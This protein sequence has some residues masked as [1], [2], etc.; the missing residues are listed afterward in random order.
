MR[1][2][3]VAAVQQI[4]DS[5]PGPDARADRAA[6]G[7]ET[8]YATFLMDRDQIADQQRPVQLFLIDAQMSGVPH[9]R[10]GSGDP[11]VAGTGEDHYRQ[12]TSAHPGV[13]PGGG[14]CFRFGLD[15]PGILRQQNGADIGAPVILQPL[16]RDGRVAV[17]L[18]AQQRYGILQIHCWRCVQMRNAPRPS[19]SAGCPVSGEYRR[20]QSQ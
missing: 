11:L 16:L 17:D 3:F 15:V 12:L 9:H 19:R 18:T 8:A 10:H 20:R 6:V 5:C 2:G 1:N 13:A 14:P 7:R 4:S